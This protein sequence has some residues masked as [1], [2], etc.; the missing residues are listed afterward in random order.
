MHPG[1]SAVVPEHLPSHL[2]DRDVVRGAVVEATAAAET[3]AVL[4]VAAHRLARGLVRLRN[5]FFAFFSRCVL[6]TRVSFV[7]SARRA[8]VTESTGIVERNR[9]RRWVSRFRKH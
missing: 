3:P 8:F 9:R 6:E 5:A 1:V 2:R 7:V 4:K